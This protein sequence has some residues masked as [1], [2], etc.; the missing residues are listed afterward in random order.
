MK[1]IYIILG[2]TAIIG[3]SLMLFFFGPTEEK[4]HGKI[5]LGYSDDSSGFVVDYMKGQKYFKDSEIKK[6]IEPASIRDC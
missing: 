6:I 4:V 1:K 2:W 5:R 3:V